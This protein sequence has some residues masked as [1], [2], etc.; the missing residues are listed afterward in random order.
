MKKLIDLHCHSN[1]S[2]GSMTPAELVE[3][4]KKSS[5]T[6]IAL[7]DHDTTSG[8]DEAISAANNLSIELIP[9]IE[10]SVSSITETHILGYFIDYKSDI[11]R[12][13][14][15]KSLEFRR[16]R[17][18]ETAEMLA[19][20]GMDISCDEVYSSFESDIIGRAHFAYL[21]VKKGY[22]SS[23]KEGFDRYLSNNRPAY[24][25]LQYFSPE[26]AIDLIH[27]SGGIAFAAHLHQMRLDDDK[28]FS[29]LSYLKEA[30]LDGIE[31]YYTEYTPEMGIKFRAMANKLDFVLSG[32]TDFHAK[33]KPQISIG[34]GYGDLEI[35]YSILDA[36]KEYHRQRT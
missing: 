25:S 14:L 31:G 10:L 30:G 23:V 4:A 11:M 36:M 28:L 18:E 32:G 9:A 21:M 24:S 35:D 15:A 1:K 27:R 2:D 16:K 17:N 5:L 34:R 19:S 13:E 20:L 33:M 12:S 22:V 8:L 6:A 7:S 29:Y 3:H 26:G